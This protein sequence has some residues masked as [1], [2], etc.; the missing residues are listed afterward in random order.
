MKLNEHKLIY[1]WTTVKVFKDSQLKI[2]Q[3]ELY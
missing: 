2:P 1:I 3:S